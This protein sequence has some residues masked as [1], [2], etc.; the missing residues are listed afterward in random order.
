MLGNAAEWCVDWNGPH[1]GGHVIDPVGPSTG[2]YHVRKGG[3]WSSLATQTR[4]GYRNW[5]E[6]T[7]RWM[8]L[9]FR[10]ALAPSL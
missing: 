7:Y 9:G 4:A 1:P 8:N 6:P 10:V 2:Q 3:S 5:H